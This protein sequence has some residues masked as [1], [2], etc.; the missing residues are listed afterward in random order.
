[1]DQRLWDTNFWNK[2]AIFR[3][4]IALREF[5]SKRQDKAAVGGEWRLLYERLT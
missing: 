4:L 2:N 3:R 5:D 1:L